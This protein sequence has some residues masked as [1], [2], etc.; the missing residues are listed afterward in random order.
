M[1]NFNRISMLYD[2]PYSPTENIKGIFSYDT[3][4]HLM[5]SFV[6]NKF[7]TLTYESLRKEFLNYN[8][9]Y[10]DLCCVLDVKKEVL[11]KIGS[12]LKLYF[13]SM[14]PK[15]IL[16]TA[17]IAKL[18]VNEGFFDDGVYTKLNILADNITEMFETI[19]VI[20]TLKHTIQIQ[21]IIIPIDERKEVDEIEVAEL[22]SNTYKYQVDNIIFTCS[23]DY[24][25]EKS[26]LSTFQT[27]YQVTI[28]VV[29]IISEG[30]L[31]LDAGNYT[32]NNMPA[33][34]VPVNLIPQLS[35][36]WS[37]LFISQNSPYFGSELYNFDMGKPYNR[38]I[39][40]LITDATSANNIK[41]LL[42]KL[43]YSLHLRRKTYE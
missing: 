9:Q 7:A 12:E 31:Q 34:I 29:S 4:G 5:S 20:N 16:I 32:I 38:Y 33:S 22:I 8:L 15:A 24:M 23:N 13:S 26:P 28:T 19:N 30:T 25:I 42:S 1:L 21:T 37:R 14:E 11:K 36:T 39:N 41:Y 27:S 35:T 17:K 18:L 2:M 3:R 10:A 40:I 43:V 6:Y